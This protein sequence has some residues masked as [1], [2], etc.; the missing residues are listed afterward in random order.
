MKTM[1][2]VFFALAMAVAAW[3]GEWHVETVD[4]EGWIGSYTSL[5][6]DASGYPHISYSGEDDLK[7]AYW[8]GSSWQTETVDSEGNVG[9]YTSLA[10]DSSDC[11]HIS[12]S[13][14]TNFDLKYA[15]WNGGSWQIE[16][17][18]SEG[19]VGWYTSLA[20]E[21]SD[22]PCISY[23]DMTNCA[24]KYARWNGSSW[25]TETVDTDE[26]VGEYTSLALDSSDYPH[27]SYYY[28][29]YD[30]NDC[31]YSIG[32]LKYTR[33]DGDSWH[34]EVV[35]DE[36]YDVGLWT[37]LALDS[38][39]YPHISYYEFAN[40]DLR[41]ARWNGGSW[42]R[43]AVESAGDVGYYTS[44]ALDSSD[45]PC[46]SY[47][48]KT[49]GDLKYA[50]WNGSGWWKTVVD[51]TGDVGWFTSLALDSDGSPRISYYDRTNGHLKYAWYESGPGVKGAEVH[52]NV[53]GEGVLVGWSV[54]GDAPAS[55][56]VLRGGVEPAAI[57]GTLPGEA[58]RY[59]D[60]G[61]EPGGSYIYWLEV[62]EAEG[63]VS[64]F[65]PT[66][67]VVFPGTARE[68]ALS[69]YPSPA[70]GSVTVEFTL[71]EEGRVTVVLYDLSG[72]RVMT[73]YD[74]ETT[75]GRHELSCDT[76]ALTPGVYLVRLAADT[77]TLTQR[78]VIAR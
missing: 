10:L 11:P 62:T 50:R 78:V 77:G 9:G 54:T 48:D 22:R 16:T 31:A 55:V 61:V 14:N 41:Y 71:P 74:G 51:S 59:L 47:Y 44:L 49:N 67:V 28:C 1:Y 65:G 5:A 43:E 3:A 38:S 69:V 52:A 58:A 63:K 56:R 23:Y 32:K 33:W 72:R 18:D 64:R 29:S 70:A 20:L 27:I 4:A 15:H 25:Q 30:R 7:Y 73:V 21:S 19:H 17:V 45:R 60:R 35:D 57:S 6:L 34:I 2:C 66:E 76:A 75:T 36:E 68:L 26:D 39:E 24:L 46:I 40:G 12:Y 42:Q 13:D 8:N 37:S 53:C